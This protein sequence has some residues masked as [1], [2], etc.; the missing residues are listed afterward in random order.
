M[1]SSLIGRLRL[2]GAFELFAALGAL[3]GGIAFVLRPDGS[4]LGMPLSLLAGSPFSTYF[5]PGLLLLVVLG[6]CNSAAAILALLRRP[7]AGIAAGVAGMSLMIW[8]AVQLQLLGYIHPL[9]PIIFTIGLIVL[10]LG[11]H[12]FGAERR[13]G[14][15]QGAGHAHAGA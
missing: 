3:Y 6:G 7:S 1:H 8:I 15:G 11:A 5:V 4:L 14:P 13:G 2:L 9:Q 12:V 10:A